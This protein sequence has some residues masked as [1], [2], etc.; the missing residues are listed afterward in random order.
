MVKSMKVRNYEKR[1]LLIFLIIVFLLLEIIG[2]IYLFERKEFKYYKISGIVSNKNIVTIIANSKE[3]K[4]INKNQTI[5]LDN[6]NIKYKILENRGVIV[7]KNNKAYYEILIQL[8]L[9]EKVKTTD[10][11]E[12]SIRDKKESIIKILNDIWKG[13]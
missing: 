7:K 3:K 2:L 12:F 10:V 8:S 6:K 1:D 11:L 13:G 4:L 5:Y 9:S